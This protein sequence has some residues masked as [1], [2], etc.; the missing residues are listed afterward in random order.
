M[1]ERLK[2]L[3]SKTSGRKPS[4]VQILYPPLDNTPEIRYN[5]VMKDNTLLVGAATIYKQP[6]RKEDQWFVV[7]TSE[8]GDWELPKTVV[9][10][11]ES[12]VRS[13]IRLTQEQGSMRTKVLEEVGRAS[14]A[15]RVNGKAVNQKY[16]YYLMHCKDVGEIMG[17][18]EYMWV[19]HKKALKMLTLKRDQNMLKEAKSILKNYEKVKGKVSNDSYEEL[20]ETEEPVV[21]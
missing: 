4:Q 3:V 21:S 18:S 19:D 12:S 8:E 5:T 1:A 9:R 11:G 14:G 2:A 15:G 6:K 16:I 20:I 13:V 7:K 17:F 10:R